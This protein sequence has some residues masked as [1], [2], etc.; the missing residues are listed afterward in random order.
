[1]A[2]KE[3]RSFTHR[4]CEYFPC[5]S[6]VAAEDFNCLF[7]FCPLYFLEEDCGGDFCFTEGGIKDCGC[8]TL[9]HSPGGYDFIEAQLEKAA[10]RIK[11]KKTEEQKND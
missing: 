7:C 2:D 9:P 10:K 1:M 6:A 11:N 3:Y 8:C 5:H 4:R